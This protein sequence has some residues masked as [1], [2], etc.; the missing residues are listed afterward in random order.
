ME[1]PQELLNK[2]AKFLKQDQL[3]SYAQ[4]PARQQVAPYIM[5]NDLLTMP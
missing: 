2:F 4:L 3:R 1:D 5:I